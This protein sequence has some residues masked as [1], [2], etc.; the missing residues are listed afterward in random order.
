[1]IDLEKN[2]KHGIGILK[3]S[4]FPVDIQPINYLTST[5]M[6]CNQLEFDEPIRG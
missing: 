6:I 3:I 2:T 1:M 5:P 4:F